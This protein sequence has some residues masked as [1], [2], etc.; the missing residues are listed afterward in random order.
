MVKSTGLVVAASD[1]MHDDGWCRPQIR[2]SLVAAVNASE[3]RVGVWVKRDEGSADR[4]VFTVM[5]NRAPAKVQIV[6]FDQAVEISI[7]VN[8]ADGDEIDLRISTPHVADNAVDQ[9]DL[10]F[11]LSSLAFV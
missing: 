8:L 5:S 7:P 4:T 1:G 2:L 3:L 9:R 11:I 6:P 10:G